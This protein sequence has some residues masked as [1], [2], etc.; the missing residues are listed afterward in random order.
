MKATT[1]RTVDLWLRWMPAADITILAVLSFLTALR[2]ADPLHRP[3]AGLEE[4]GGE[5][6]GRRGK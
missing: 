2:L 4:G 3:V 5:G 1:H 6:R